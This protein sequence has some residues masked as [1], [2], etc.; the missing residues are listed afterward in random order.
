M[1]LE[2]FLPVGLNTAQGRFKQKNVNESLVCSECGYVE[3]YL[4]E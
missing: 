1:V 4:K 3:L 2:S